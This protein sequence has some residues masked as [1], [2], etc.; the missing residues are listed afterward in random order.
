MTINNSN[1]CDG[2]QKIHTSWKSRD[3]YFMRKRIK[4]LCS[5]LYGD[6]KVRSEISL[7]I[8]PAWLLQQ[9]L[10]YLTHPIHFLVLVI[11]VVQ[12]VAIAWFAPQ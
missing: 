1:F 4:R 7:F 3:G 5:A 9:A 10:Y 8:E 6:T 11:Q 2:D 12:V